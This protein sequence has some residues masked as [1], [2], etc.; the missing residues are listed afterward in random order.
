MGKLSHREA[1]PP[2]KLTPVVKG[3]NRLRTQIL[4][5]ILAFTHPLVNPLLGDTEWLGTHEKAP[6]HGISPLSALPRHHPGCNLRWL[7]SAHP[8]SLD[9]MAQQ[10]PPCRPTQQVLSEHLP[11]GYLRGPGDAGITQRA[12]SARCQEAYMNVG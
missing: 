12:P 10:G 1:K 5:V 2:A 11:F 4:Q 7:S 8:G 6:P 9:H 3:R